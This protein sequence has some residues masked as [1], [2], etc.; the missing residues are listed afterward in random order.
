MVV[1]CRQGNYVRVIGTLREYEGKKHIFVFKIAAIQDWNEVTHH[2]LEVIAVHLRHT[3]GP[4]LVRYIDL[5]ELLL[6]HNDIILNIGI[7]V[8]WTT[9]GK[10][11]CISSRSK[12]Y[13]IYISVIFSSSNIIYVCV[14]IAVGR[15]GFNNNPFNNVGGTRLVV[16]DEKSNDLAH[17]VLFINIVMYYYTV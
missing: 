13:S 3:K 10:S 5:Y 12:I 2:F 16:N 1:I 7:K 11:I 4:I 8:C 9:D 17:K 14:C 15:G 6:C